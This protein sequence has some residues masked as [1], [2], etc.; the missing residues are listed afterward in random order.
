MIVGAVP[1]GEPV[2]PASRALTVSKARSQQLRLGLLLL[3][4]HLVLGAA[5]VFVARRDPRLLP[6]LEALFL[7]SLLLSWAAV[8]SFGATREVARIGADLLADGDFTT[9]LRPVGQP[10]ADL[11]VTV[12]NRM[13]AALRE[14]RLRLEERDLFLGRLL[15]ASPA[16]VVTLDLTGRVAEVNPA[17]ARLLGSE[18]APLLGSELASAEI[19]LLAAL[20]TV[21]PGRSSVVACG[22]RRRLRVQHGEFSDRGFRRSFFL[23]E[24]LTDELRASEK[25]AYE[26]LVRLVAHEVNNSVGAVRSLLDSCRAMLAEGDDEPRSGAAT[27]PT[28]TTRVE[29]DGALEVAATRLVH[30][31]SFVEGFAAIVRLPAPERRPLAAGELIDRLLVLVRGE[32]ER[33]GIVVV[34]TRRD[35]VPPIVADPAQL[36]QVLLNVLKN[37]I[38]AT[39]QGAQGT[40]RDGGAPAEIVVAAAPAATDAPGIAPPRLH[41]AL[42]AVGGADPGGRREAPRGG[43]LRIRD[44][45]PGLSVGA[46]ERIFTPFFTT[47]PDGRGL[48]LTL[49]AEVLDAH[50]FTY[51]L[52]NHPAGGAELMIRW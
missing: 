41:L 23:L 12:Y 30:L 27:T 4:V 13:A 31:A 49:T 29:V 37:A 9:Q 10:D 3:A 44:E 14:E 46:A 24:E 32:L 40:Q 50:G 21:P 26:R 6:L 34:W 48:G 36:E 51:A 1:G 11:L 33:H 47:K 43:I 39:V 20:A 2:G 22:G 25:Q 17:A 16:G 18:E 38:E 15:A 19:P 42:E 8:R 7:V 52:G 35:E 5:A 28:A 45:G